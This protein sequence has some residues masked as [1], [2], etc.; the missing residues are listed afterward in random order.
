M[1]FEKFLIRRIITFIPTLLGV[2]FI[3]YI[4]A[5]AVPADPVRA[6]VSEKL[7]DP[8]IIE[9][10]RAQYKFNAPWY[11]QFIFLVTSFLRGELEDPVRHKN[12][13]D[14]IASRFPVTVELAVVSF[15]FL[16]ALSLPLGLLA[17]LRKDSAVDF[18]VRILAL[19][20]SSMPSFVLYYLMI[21]VFFTYL[22]AT[23]LAGIP[24]PSDQCIATI[25]SY[26]SY[27]VVGVVITSI[28]SVPMF[29]AAMC[30]EWNVVIDSLKRLYVPALSL[31]LLNSGFIARIVRN[32]FLD[33]M[34]SEYILYARARGLRKSNIFK[35]AFKNAFIPV[36]TI[37]GLSFG[38]LL[39]GAVIAETVFNIPGLGKYMYDSITRLNFPALIGS[40]FVVAVVYLIVNLVVDILYAYID[41]RIR[42]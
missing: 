5:Y 4:I 40:V 6:W 21:L 29:G 34:G 11:E 12:V 28:G 7:M 8:S 30:G 1:G 33:S 23:Y 37:L 9:R 20:G 26:S 32:S 10:I 2:L 31:A 42:Y 17:A 13:F 16:V 15:I 36:L 3:T 14:E 18:F 27:P 39:S 38:G 41:P 19:F 22:G 25:N 24:M 35:H